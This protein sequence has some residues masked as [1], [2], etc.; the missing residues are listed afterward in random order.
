MCVVRS[1]I[2]R[3]LYEL[4]L[5]INKEEIILVKSSR[6]RATGKTRVIFVSYLYAVH[7]PTL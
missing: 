4:D 1:S 6:L 2:T 3:E 5:N 7:Q